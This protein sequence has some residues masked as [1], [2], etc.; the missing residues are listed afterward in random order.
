MAGA[1]PQ[2]VRLSGAAVPLD[3]AAIVPNGSQDLL[4]FAH[5]AGAGYDHAN[6]VSIAHALAAL[7]IATLR[8]N[9]P[10]WQQGKRRVDRPEIATAAIAAAV[11]HAAER[12]ASHRL[13][14]GGH[15]FGG[16]MASHAVLDHELPVLGLVFGSFPL[17]PAKQPARTRAAHLPAVTLPMLFLSGTRDALAEPDL[18]TEV[19]DGLGSRARL[20][21]LDTADHGYKVLKRSRQRTD[22]V[23]EEMAAA[24]QCFVR[25]PAC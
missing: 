3:G 22:T 2:A 19:V 4:V 7:G 21:W 24:T 10:Y 15:S 11:T 16:R 13:W 23:F 9:F 1:A 6:L 25:A 12:F 20:V 18:L 17:H 14:L 5:G 8:F